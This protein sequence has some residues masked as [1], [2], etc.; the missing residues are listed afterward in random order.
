MEGPRAPAAPTIL[1]VHKLGTHTITPIAVTLHELPCQVRTTP[2]TSLAW[3]V[4]ESDPLHN[5]ANTG[6]GTLV[7]TLCLMILE[8]RSPVCVLMPPAPELTGAL[9][10]STARTKAEPSAQRHTR[11]RPRQFARKT[12]T[13]KTVLECL[14]SSCSLLRRLLVS[15][16]HITPRLQAPFLHIHA[17]AHTVPFVII[18]N[19]QK[20]SSTGSSRPSD[21]SLPQFIV[22]QLQ[23][24]ASRTR[25]TALVVS[26]LWAPTW[27][28]LQALWSLRT[29]QLPHLQQPPLEHARA[30]ESH[31]ERSPHR[32]TQPRPPIPPAGALCTGPLFP[33]PSSIPPLLLPPSPVPLPP[34]TP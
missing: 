21:I 11:Y 28:P 20:A 9:P 16:A 4:V 26:L 30:R 5:C 22:H 34:L 14:M 25:P 6:F 13:H 3:S 7:S 12:Q 19:G 8:T 17:R 1:P 10:Y 18:S 31:A 33:S 15:P 24:V 32:H 23:Q 29:G 2:R 27:T